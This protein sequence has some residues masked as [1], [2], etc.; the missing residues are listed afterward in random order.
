MI[1][2]RINTLVLLSQMFNIENTNLENQKF[3]FDRRL[4]RPTEACRQPG[5]GRTVR[6]PA[7]AHRPPDP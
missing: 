3:T 1:L 2:S 6:R 4:D 5:V 7:A